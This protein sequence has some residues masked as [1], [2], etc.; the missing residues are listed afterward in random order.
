MHISRNVHL[1]A[2]LGLVSMMLLY[3][4]V[5]AIVSVGLRRFVMHKIRLL[6]RDNTCPACNLHIIIG[7]A[8]C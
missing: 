3:A 2:V 4:T 7:I 1:L 6:W 8:A 5:H